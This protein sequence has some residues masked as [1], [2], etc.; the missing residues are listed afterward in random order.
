MHI[1]TEPWQDQLHR[2]NQTPDWTSGEGIRCADA[3]IGLSVFASR[4]WLQER[5]T[6]RAFYQSMLAHMPPETFGF[7][8][9][10]SMS[11]HRK[12]TAATFEMLG[13][14]LEDGAPERGF[15]ALE[16]KGG[17]G[18]ADASADLFKVFGLEPG[19]DEYDPL[20]AKSLSLSLRPGA[21]T[22]A[23]DVAWIEQMFLA[24]CARVQLVS[25]IAG[26]VVNTSRYDKAVAET[27]AWQA[28]TRYRGLDIPALVADGIAVSEAGL[29][30]VA[31]LTALGEPVL[32][33][34]GG[35]AAVLSALPKAVAVTELP[36]GI[37]LKLAAA[38]SLLDRNR[39]EDAA[40]YHRAY[41]VVQ[42]AIEYYIRRSATLSLPSDA[43]EK[44][45]RWL[46]RFADA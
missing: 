11:R 30:G 4:P 39:N 42:P 31:W 2:V 43:E 13:L 25:A 3:G 33:S 23:Q 28:A 7:Y 5:D 14:W 6:L 22:A 27:V 40:L 10:E 12:S 8:A 26:P 36:T 18:P 20:D 44:S 46:R 38:P 15:V 9:T 35:R 16:L 41:A 17:G 1:P 32:D 45:E 24:V 21:H 34:L 29:K 37:V 19:N